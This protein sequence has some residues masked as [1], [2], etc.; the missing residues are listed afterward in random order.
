MS[1]KIMT[2]VWGADLSHR[3]ILVLMALADH[4]DHDGNN[5]YPAIRRLAWKVGYSETTVRRAL[6]SMTEAGILTANERPGYTTNYSIHIDKIPHKPYP[7]QNATP[8]KAMGGGGCQNDRGTPI[9]QMVGESSLEPSY[10]RHSPA[11]QETAPDDDSIPHQL[12]G[13]EADERP[14]HGAYDCHQ[15]PLVCDPCSFASME[16]D[17]PPTALQVQEPAPCGNPEMNCVNCLA[18]NSPHCKLQYGNEADGTPAK[19]DPFEDK[20]SPDAPKPT[21]L[22]VKPGTLQ[23]PVVVNF[24]DVKDHWNKDAQTW[25]DPRYVYIGRAVP[26]YRLKSSKWQ[27]KFTTAR[28]GRFGAIQLYRQALDGL[29]NDLHELTGKT[30]VCWCK[31]EACHGDVLVELWHEHV[32][33]SGVALEEAPVE[34]TPKPKPPR[35]PTEH[36]RMFAA[37]RDGLGWDVFTD[38]HNKRIGKIASELLS[39]TDRDGNPRPANPDHI[40]Y[41][42]NWMKINNVLW[43]N[44]EII[45]SQWPKFYA[46]KGA[47]LEMMDAYPKQEKP[48]TPDE[49]I[50]DADRAN[51]FEMRRLLLVSM[52]TPLYSHEDNQ[53]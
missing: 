52:Q 45:L 24:H 49:P 10:N 27:N 40:P 37:I 1:I 2:E 53:S 18:Y 11:T 13:K 44:P 23:P 20:N 4:A 42:F 46:E 30:L 48:T 29:A 9:T 6:Q 43:Q 22:H 50:S 19:P 7:S 28:H 15:S 21:P 3:D 25:D 8:S 17:E 35:K 33:R 32:G 51:F 36:Q 16:A 26:R 12:G 31:P 14:C 5:A 39:L 47:V 34:P 41:F 38:S